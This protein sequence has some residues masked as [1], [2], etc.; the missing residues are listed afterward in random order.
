[1]I[2][3]LLSIVLFVINYSKVE[4]IKYQLTGKTFSSNVERSNHLKQILDEHGEEINILPLQGFIFFG[5]A[6]RLLIQV[7]LRQKDKTLDELKYLVFDFRHVTGLDSS[8]INSFNKLRI[9]ADN[10]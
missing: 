5:T 7:Q 10:C 8:A 4:V 1:M 2:V 9:L 3:L 6:N